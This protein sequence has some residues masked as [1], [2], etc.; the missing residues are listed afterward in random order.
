MGEVHLQARAVNA[1]TAAQSP[2]LVPTSASPLAPA[3]THTIDPSTYRV[4][5]FIAGPATSVKITIVGIQAI[6][7][8]PDKG[9][10]LFGNA[11][12][13]GPGIEVTLTNGTIDLAAAGL[14]LNSI[15]VGHYKGI[16]LFLSR[17]VKLKGCVTGVFDAH[18]A[19]TGTY[20][21]ATYTNDAVTAGTHQFCTIAS[22]S[23]LDHYNGTVTPSGP[24]GTDAEYEAQTTPEDVEID[25]GN[26]FGTSSGGYPSSAAEVRAESTGIDAL[27]D[28]DVDA[29]NPVELTV[30]V[31]MNRM[32]HFWPNITFNGAASF[33]PP[34][35]QAYP[36]GTSY[37][38]SDGFTRAIAL[39]AGEPGSVEGYQLTSEICQFSPCN[40]G[41]PPDALSRGWMT[42]IRD[43][44]GVIGSGSVTPDDAPDSVHGDVIPTMTIDTAG[45]VHLSLGLYRNFVEEHGYI[46]G[47]KFKN[48][49]DPEDSASAYPTMGPWAGYGPYAL[50]YTR[51]L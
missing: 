21:G 4:H 46:D 16:H 40:S 14:Q 47:F 7:E 29:D 30:I 33:Q 35:P 3:A 31:D 43:S 49:G 24:V 19:V 22:K 2:R 1:G 10:I 15:P 12:W 9:A 5:A 17:A 41:A 6:G 28:F 20:N 48:L 8:T 51:K 13:S 36:P 26:G 18:S 42:L 39:F 11:N 44:N 27:S 37:F 50:W 38:Y 23:I 34:Q 25:G 32:L 45:T